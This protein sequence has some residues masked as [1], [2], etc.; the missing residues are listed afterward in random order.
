MNSPGPLFKRSGG[1]K[2]IPPS[3]LKRGLG[4]V[5]EIMKTQN[6]LLNQ[7]QLLRTGFVSLVGAGPG[8]PKLLT[9]RGREAL[10]NCD[11]VIY[12]RLVHE[13]ILSFAK[14][15]KLIYAGKRGGYAHSPS[16]SLIEK[17]IIQ[18]ARAGKQVVRLKGGDPF[19]FGRGGEEALTLAK[20]KIPFEIVP[21]VSSG[22]AVPAYAG[23]PVTHRG[24]ASSVTFITAHE[25][26]LKHGA[27]ID[28][29]AIS[30]LPGTLVL[31]MAMKTLQETVKQLIHLG[32]SPKTLVALI[33]EGTT[34]RQKVIQ[35]TLSTIVELSKQQK[36]KPPT[37]AVI[38]EVCRFGK[39]LAWFEK[40]PLTGKH[41]LIT[42]PKHQA[43][44][45][46]NALE[47]SSARVTVLPTISIAP[48]QNQFQV[49]KTIQTLGFDDWVVFTSA[50]GVS[51]F[52]DAMHQFGRDARS[53]G[54][55]KIAAIG[56]RTLEE[57][58]AH[59]ILADLIPKVFTTEGLLRAFEKSG[60]RGKKF[61]L[62]RTNI[63]PKFLMKELRRLG[64][65]VREVV[66]YETK[67]PP[68]LKTQLIQ[69]FKKER[70]DCVTFTS[71]S[72]AAN[73]YESLPKEKRLMV[74]AISIGPVTSRAIRAAGG[75][76]A[77]EAREATVKGL[78]RAIQD[79]VRIKVV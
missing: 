60:V 20:L 4:G 52:F 15:A 50:N 53:F 16:Q 63:A 62:L 21:G 45:L 14:K 73:F 78:V 26:P 75:R 49:K 44:E 51:A 30:S 56:P 5:G 12:D 67:K 70:I 46:V 29:K 1:D 39:K 27:K 64:G 43:L 32:K 58:Q 48:V 76:V 18:F 54:K 72:T 65:I 59:G 31:F 8:D 7:K 36:L 33:Q 25:D 24:I 40:R 61:L 34:E 57:L 9:I 35:G 22:Y 71:A 28:W 3:L 38:G 47:H 74:K 6:I 42:R 17:K 77:R 68:H 23:I 66:V 37:L 79:S 11:V 10:E 2:S 69:L 19:V 55:S 41:I 13:H